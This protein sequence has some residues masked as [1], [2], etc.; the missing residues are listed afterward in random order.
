MM[1]TRMMRVVQFS[2]ASVLVLAAVT[3][4]YIGRSSWGMAF[5]F[6]LACGIGLILA[7]WWAFLLAAIPWP[8][9]VGLSLATKPY[10]FLGEA[11]Q[12]AAFISILVG[13]I[14]VALGVAVRRGLRYRV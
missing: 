4:H 6:A 13:L 3:E 1:N 9:G 7:R 5:W 8:V 11:W 14:G 10:A 12:F 2:A